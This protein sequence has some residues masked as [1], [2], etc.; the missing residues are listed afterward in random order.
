MASFLDD[1]VGKVVQ[2]LKDKGIYN[3]TIIIFVAEYV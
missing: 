2:A 3:D 1:G